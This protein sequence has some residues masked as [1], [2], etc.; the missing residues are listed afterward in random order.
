[1]AAAPVAM[2][3][4]IGKL[5]TN[6]MRGLPKVVP[7]LSALLLVGRSLRIVYTKFYGSL[8]TSDGS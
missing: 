1:M 7:R 5:L 3:N 4:G 8:T 6:E 2:V